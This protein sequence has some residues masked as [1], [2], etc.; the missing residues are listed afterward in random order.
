MKNV[1]PKHHVLFVEPDRVVAESYQKAF[2]QINIEADWE[3]TA[4]GAVNSIDQIKPELIIL[5]LQLPGN[6]GIEFIHELRSYTDWQDIPIVLFTL[7]PEHELGLS[8]EIKQQFGIIG[9]YYKPQTSLEKILHFVE[10]RV[11]SN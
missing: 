3:S 1:H 5:E 2:R 8:E 6:N 4:Q 7:V 9:Y 10:A 11:T